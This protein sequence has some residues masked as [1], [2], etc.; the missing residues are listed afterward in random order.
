M[1]HRRIAI[2]GTAPSWNLTPWADT[3]LE[4]WSL[5]DA[6]NIDGLQRADVWYDLHPLD[7]FFFAPK[8]EP[9]KKVGIFAH[10]IPQGYYVRPHSHLEWLATAPIPKYLHPDFATQKP[11][12][13]NWPNVKAFPKAD[14]EAE[15]GH[16]CTSSPQ[17]MLAHALMLGIREV[18]IY[19]IHL[20]TESEYIDQRPGF[21]FIIGCLL[22]AGKR[23]LT[24]KN[25]LRHY[26]S[27]DGLV[28]L[29]EASP[30]LSSKFQ[31]AFEPSP[32]KQLE[33]L[34][35]ELHKAQIK[36]ARTVGALKQAT[37]P[38]TSIIE[39]IPNDPEGK[40]QKRWVRTSTLQQEVWHHEALVQDCQD[41]L[42][43]ASA[44]V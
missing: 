22:G 43:R 21:E 26:E 1:S 10:Q 20:S 32:R 19:G 38:I 15:Y 7:K 23:K 9:G 34:H 6:Y 39:P 40:T 2:V 17:W 18:H 42:A 33:P 44:G 35:W 30:V 12:A 11:E 29:P 37:W 14:I 41:A 4:I 3:S 25:G 28:V 8:P 16:Y 5:N 13:A 24:I 36:L 27:A 31:Y